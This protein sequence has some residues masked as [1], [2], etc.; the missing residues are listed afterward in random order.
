MK[1]KIR[2]PELV[3]SVKVQQV[4]SKEIYI[5]SLKRKSKNWILPVKILGPVIIEEVVPERLLFLDEEDYY[6]ALQARE[7]QKTSTKK[8]MLS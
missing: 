1:L 7:V 3:Y 5:F 8:T 2:Q 4:P 6:P